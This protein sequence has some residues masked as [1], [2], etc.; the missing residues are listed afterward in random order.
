MKMKLFIGTFL[1]DANGTKDVVE[2]LQSSLEKSNI[3]IKLVSKHQNKIIRIIDIISSIILNNEKLIFFNVFSGMAFKMTQWGSFIA[4]LKNKKIIYTLHGGALH[5]FADKNN[6][7]VKTVFNRA[8][9]IQTPSLFLKKY[10]EAQGFNIHYLP[11]P[12]NF[13]NFQYQRKHIKPHT[14]LWV[15]AFTEIYNP[16][17]AINILNEVK[18]KYP[19]ATLTMVGPDKGLLPQIKQQIHALGLEQSVQIIGPVANHELHKYYQSHQVYINTTSYESFGMAIVEAAACGIPIISSSVGE[20]PYLWT[21]E[22]NMMLVNSLNATDFSMSI[23]KLF[24]DENLANNLST[25]AKQNVEQ[26]DWKY[27]KPQWIKLLNN[28][29]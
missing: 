27:I 22:K 3:H 8:D 17:L 18:K 24:E 10:F 16:A 29:F 15:R 2:V 28:E 23:N 9:Y 19:A 5:E 12:I 13:D 26:F 6:E 4:K 7:L 25:N 1:S 14:I 21:N 20:I 11:N